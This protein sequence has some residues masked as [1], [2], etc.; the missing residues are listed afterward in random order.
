MQLNKAFLYIT[1]INT[2]STLVA[3]YGLMLLRRIFTPELEEK[4][5]IGGKIASIQMC[6]IASIIPSL[7]LNSLLVNHKLPCTKI[8]SPKTVAEGI[9][10]HHIDA[11]YI[12]SVA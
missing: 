6:L 3:V 2:T 5:K 11:Q 4:F 8:L 7:V 10:N 12:C 1:I 9:V